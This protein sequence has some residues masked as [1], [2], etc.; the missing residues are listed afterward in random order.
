MATRRITATVTLEET[1]AAGLSYPTYR[2]LVETKITI[3]LPVPNEAELPYYLSQQIS[4]FLSIATE[5]GAEPQDPNPI[6]DA[7][8]GSDDDSEPAD[9]DVLSAVPR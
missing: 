1:S 3:S 4:G 7:P 8:P 6:D 5:A 2:D 9:G